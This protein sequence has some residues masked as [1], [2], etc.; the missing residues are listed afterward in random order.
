M[1]R[2]SEQVVSSPEARLTSGSEPTNHPGCPSP[3]AAN[4]ASK[5]RYRLA[6]V[7]PR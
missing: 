2:L 6:V 4:A 7:E 1:P 3:Q 5:N